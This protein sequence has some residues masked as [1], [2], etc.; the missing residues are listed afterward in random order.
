V[1]TVAAEL[2]EM[3]HV[4]ALLVLGAF[5]GLPAPPMQIS[6]DLMPL[7]EAEMMLMTEKVD[8]AHEPLSRLFSV[9]E[10]G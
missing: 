7:L 6:L 9:F 4:F 10:I 3:E 2:E 5:V 8:T 1:E